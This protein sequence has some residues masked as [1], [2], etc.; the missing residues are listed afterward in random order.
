MVKTFGNNTLI[1]LLGNN[2]KIEVKKHWFKKLIFKNLKTKK[3]NL[4]TVYI[5]NK[6]ADSMVC[7]T[8]S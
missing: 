3:K 7:P 4:Q 1:K 2:K 6:K 5:A 8:R